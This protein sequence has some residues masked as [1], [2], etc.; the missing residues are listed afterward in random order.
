[1]VGADRH[2]SVPR[3][4]CNELRQY[5][6]PKF[7]EEG[8]K[9]TLLDDLE[10][11]EISGSVF[12]TLKEED[13]GKLLPNAKFGALR[14]LTMIIKELSES[15]LPPTE[16]EGRV[17]LRKFDTPV[18]HMDKYHLGR[19]CDTSSCVADKTTQ[20]LRL[21]NIIETD[22]NREESLEFIGS[23][24]VKFA[25]ACIN[26]RRNGTVYFGVSPDGSRNLKV[27][28]IVGVDI[29][30]EEVEE[31]IRRYL[32]KCF[33]P[34]QRYV[35]KN[36]V[37]DPKFV[38]VID[39]SKSGKK[40][41]VVEIDIC[42]SQNIVKDGRIITLHELEGF[43][44]SHNDGMYGFSDVGLP[45]LLSSNERRLFENDHRLIVSQR[46][47]E[48]T[49]KKSVSLVDLR[50]KLLGLFTGGHNVMQDAVHFFL[51]LSP[52]SDHMDQQYISENLL[53]AKELKP[54]LVLD[55]DPNGST[56]GVY[57]NLDEKQDDSMRV[58]IPE[59]FD[60]PKNQNQ[61]L[62]SLKEILRA[63]VSRTAWMFC[64]GYAN[65][66][67]YSDVDWKKKRKKGFR[68]A[69]HFFIES[70]GP[71]RII[72]IVC[73]FSDNYEEMLDACDEVVSEL[74]N[75][76]IV[77][78]EC[79]E[80]ARRWSGSMLG[81]CTTVQNILR[82]RC[83]LGMR[84]SEV[85]SIFLQATQVAPRYAHTLRTSKGPF[86]EVREKMLKDWCDL[87][88]LTAGDLQVDPE[89]SSQMRKEVEQKFYKGG[90]AQ[91]LNFWFGG[92]VLEREIHKDLLSKVEMAL[93]GNYKEEE[94]M[95]TVISLLHEPGAGATTS[96][97]QVLW[98]LRTKYR[99]CIVQTIS[100][101]TPDQL[102]EVRRYKDTSPMPLLILVDN[103]DEDKWIQLRGSLEE[104]ARKCWRESD[105]ENPCHVYCT[106]LLCKM[107][108]S[109]PISITD[110]Q[111]VLCHSL[112]ENELKLFQ[113]KSKE[114]NKEYTKNEES[115]LLPKFLISF[116]FMKENFNQDY[117][118]RVVK[119]FSESVMKGSEI[120]LLK[121]VSFLNTYDP[122]FKPITVSALDKLIVNT[123]YASVASED[124]QRS[125]HWEA[126]LS[127]SV[128]VLLNLSTNL[129]G[130]RKP[131]TDIRVVNKNIAEKILKNM[132]I[133]S[134]QS[135]SQIMQQILKSGVFKDPELK[136]MQIMINNIVKTREIEQDGK[137]KRFSK[138][139]SD[140]E[141]NEGSETAVKVLECIFAE[142]KDA[143]T[144]QLISR[145]YI[146]LKNWPQAE[147]FACK[148]TEMVPGNSYLWDTYGQ[149]FKEQLQ[150][151]VR[152][153]ACDVHKFIEISQKAIDVFQREQAV[154]EREAGR[155]LAGY[156][157]ELW[158]TVRLLKFIAAMPH[159]NKPGDLQKFLVSEATNHH[160]RDYLT[161]EEIRFLKNLRS[162]SAK[163]TRKLDDEF[164]QMKDNSNYDGTHTGREENRSEL[165]SLKIDLGKY[166]GAPTDQVPKGLSQESQKTYRLAQIMRRG[167]NS[168]TSLLTLRSKGD[169]ESLF[170]VYTFAFQNVTQPP[171]SF[172]DAKTFLN[173]ATVLLADQRTN[174]K[175][176]TYS[177]LL[178][179]SK[180]LYSKP[181]ADDRYQDLEQYLYFIMY[182]FP[183][184]ERQNQKL[185]PIFD[186]QTAIKKWFDAFKDKYQ[187][188]PKEVNTSEKP[189]TL[190]F[191]ANGPPLHDILHQDKLDKKMKEVP[192][193]EKWKLPEV[194]QKL[195]VMKGLLDSKGERIKIYGKT[196]SGNSYEIDVP[197][198]YPVKERIMWQKKV[199][200]YL[201]FT[202]SGP[203]A[204]G[205]RSEP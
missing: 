178:E 185:C 42:P 99:C 79:E 186:L 68:N 116:N 128:K 109:L 3:M 63:E 65:M 97:R 196:G 33:D 56:E 114:L 18:D 142:N 19:C 89:K 31:I 73:L 66:P 83:V 45:K 1:M 159:F 173:V 84:W 129:E 188:H 101:S 49:E 82:K 176:L 93:M 5:L 95:V 131:R 20:P 124:G 52:L 16:S 94:T 187:K 199:Y 44:T 54:E 47:R 145:Y 183:T 27:G 119:E 172:D 60:M 2:E 180:L 43:P 148:A 88:I 204:F 195:R 123:D 39:S 6:A 87:E 29:P 198:A 61:E 9:D 125:L 8:I 64:N 191:L 194:R 106:I 10:E 34:A 75:N 164:L 48:E 98:E 86:V 107:R 135:D 174:P 71:D 11:N 171:V 90:Q 25:S 190:F 136:E 200:Y 169:E 179:M 132:K 162:S 146:N 108:S 110:D 32:G 35:V 205:V 13:L 40:L 14:K 96:A 7:Q 111:A 143:F 67:K 58:L 23:A 120:E 113:E 38:P 150:E 165:F 50:K 103:E 15:P 126:G 147:K 130:H 193:D 175:S 22:D 149:V 127:Q 36:T 117:I 21:F 157:G 17:Y 158:T 69:L 12:L 141:V 57:F 139:L 137:K 53:F 192:R 181:P 102:H 81:R 167:G 112:T 182:N 203:K 85:N 76:W 189:T 105:S 202:Y 197:T 115:Y 163:A 92:Q 152:E 77:L 156:F 140:V 153:S 78:A 46:E 91:W 170:K 168:L 55:F 80:I 28:E 134:N 161:E 26:E 62:N 184:E 121:F 144:A 24:V 133:R 30:R 166:F 4:S 72:P 70:F 201:G 118:T 177:L 155:N 104:K 122:L 160:M 138:F 154:S 59:N 151:K 51:M 74:S 100:D 41:F 37:R